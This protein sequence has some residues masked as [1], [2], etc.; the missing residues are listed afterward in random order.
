MV[1]I[2]QEKGYGWGFG[3]PTGIMFASLVILAAGFPRYR[4]KKPMGSV[5]T[6]FIQVIVVSVRNH[7]KGVKVGPKVKLYEVA[8]KESDIFGARR[9]SYTPHY[10]LAFFIL[11]WVG[12]GLL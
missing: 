1:Y 2:Q 11:V 9:L 12:L 7:F 3:L 4:Y 8:T 10:R 6:R 5:F